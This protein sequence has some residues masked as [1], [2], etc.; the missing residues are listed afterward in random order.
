MD[1]GCRGCKDCLNS[2]HIIRTVLVLVMLHVTVAVRTV[3]M[4]ISA[5]Y[6]ELIRVVVAEGL[7]ILIF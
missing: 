3:L 1:K 4:N 5:M 2:F 6:V 7:Y